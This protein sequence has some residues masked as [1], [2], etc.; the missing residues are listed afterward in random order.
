MLPAVQTAPIQPGKAEAGKDQ[1]PPAA[2]GDDT[3]ILVAAAEAL[4]DTKLT[5]NP[6]TTPK[7][8]TG[9]DAGDAAPAEAKKADKAANPDPAQAGALPIPDVPAPVATSPVIVPAAVVTGAPV[10][11]PADPPAAADG[12]AVAPATAA[13][14]IA[15][16]AIA[17]ATTA[18]TPGPQ[19]E[20]AEPAQI[21]AATVQKLQPFDGKDKPQAQK[22]AQTDSKGA[23]P[24]LQPVP[25]EDQAVPPPRTQGGATPV[26]PDAKAAAVAET[27]DKPVAKADS[28][29]D[30]IDAAVTAKLD[31]FTP[32]GLAAG[33]TIAAAGGVSPAHSPT[34][35]AA[36]NAGA[37]GP[38][39][40]PQAA[41]PVAGLA[42]EIAGRAH[43]GKNN[44]EIR[45]DPPELGRIEVKLSVD[46]Q[47]QVT[48]HLIADRADTLDL[49][50]RDATGLERALQDAGLKTGGDGLQFSLRDQSFNG[51]QN[52]DGR[53]TASQLIA[54]DDSLPAI[55]PV[56]N[57]YTRYVGRIGGIDIRV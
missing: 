1:L 13:A 18:P 50:R 40:T 2:M 5:G 6:V 4:I 11:M 37:Q 56:A 38:L 55:D 23:A 45:L 15:A 47:G 9:I 48:S 21:A 32:T 41:I 16:P 3:F 39:L 46:R 33:G 42:V 57:G 20:P 35:A 34:T 25:D 31:A 30:R 27:A 19:A 54:T 7:A 28:R 53:G 17:V 8:P 52:G 22:S 44:F 24:P 26:A 43:A 12:E 14:P 51:R 29:S 36:G 10:A 49:L